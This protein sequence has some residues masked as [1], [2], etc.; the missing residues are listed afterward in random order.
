MR[1]HMTWDESPVVVKSES[2]KNKKVAKNVRA[3]DS[4]QVRE[5]VVLKSATRK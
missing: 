2:A 4:R 3:S 1:G 5:T